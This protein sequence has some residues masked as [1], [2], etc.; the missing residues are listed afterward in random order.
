[1]TSSDGAGDL[2]AHPIH[3]NL[4]FFLERY[5]AEREHFIVILSP[6][7]IQSRW[8]SREWN[9]ALDLEDEGKLVT[10]LPVIAE[11]CA[12][13]LMLRGYMRIQ[14]PDGG[15]LSPEEAASQVARVLAQ[16]KGNGGAA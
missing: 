2:L 7:A 9:A 11:P 14:R 4:Q 10:F 13:P 15:A 8:V 12:I 5:D 3:G 1:M 16:H 6:A